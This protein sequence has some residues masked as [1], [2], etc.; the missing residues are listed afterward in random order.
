MPNDGSTRMYTSGWPKIQN[1]C[2]HSSGSAPAATEKNVAS[3][4]RWKMS[5]TSATVITGMANSSR[6]W[7]TRIIHVNTG[8]RISDMPFVRMFSAVTIRLMA[9]DCEAMPVMMRPSAQ[10]SM[11][12][13]GENVTLEFGAYMNQPPSAAPPRIHDVLMNRAPNRKLQ[14]PN[15]LIRGKATSR[16]PICSGMK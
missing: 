3:N 2:C 4:S 5:S 16:A 8:M 14:K 6:N 9:P 7:I 15:A 12:C 13:V 11:P 1:R 10:M